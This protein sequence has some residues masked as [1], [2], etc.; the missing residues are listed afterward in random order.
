MKETDLFKIINLD[1]TSLYSNIP[2]K[3]FWSNTY[4]KNKCVKI[5]NKI[6]DGRVK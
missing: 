4:R 5:L 3:F 6:K 1:F 2:R